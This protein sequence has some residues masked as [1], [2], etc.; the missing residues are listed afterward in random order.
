MNHE[1]A[2][3]SEEHRDGDRSRQD[4][5]MTIAGKAVLVT[6]AN[7]GIGQALVE[8]A[9]RRGAA[10][11]YAGARQPR[12]HPD[13]RVTPVRLDVTDKAQID[14]AVESIESLDVLVNNAGV[15]LHGD[16][17]DRAALEQHLAV[18]LF[19][20]YDVTRAL[21]PALT[22][23]RG[24]VVNVLSLAAVA[25]LPF[26]PTYSISKAA[27]FNLTQSLRAL[28]ADRGVRVHAVLTWPRGHGYDTRS[29]HT[30]G[31]AGVGRAS[32]LR[33]SREGRGGDPPRSHVS[34]DHGELG[35]R[36]DEGARAPVCGVRRSRACRRM[37]PTD[38][39]GSIAPPTGRPTHR[40]AIC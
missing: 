23:S 11:V 29:R 39:H 35:Q 1:P 37:K 15:D 16:V 30:E 32:D 28:L 19:G 4:G 26:T 20:T 36:G 2:S 6:G 18:N 9:L 22:G 24:A 21:L 12:A 25:A 33:R 14:A 13:G 3:Q 5:G 8:E 17:G 27:A 38:G 10:H 40:C 7:R 34:L 31:L